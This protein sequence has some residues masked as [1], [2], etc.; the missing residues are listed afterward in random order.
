[1]RTGPSPP[2]AILAYMCPQKRPSGR[3][4][5]LSSALFHRARP[6]AAP[7]RGMARGTSHFSARARRGGHKG[8][9]SLVAYPY[10]YFQPMLSYSYFSYC[11]VVRPLSPKVSCKTQGLCVATTSVR[12]LSSP[13]SDAATAL[14][15]RAPLAAL[16]RRHSPRHARSPRRTLTPPRPSPRAPHSQPSPH[17]LSPCRTSDRG[18]HARHAYS[19]EHATRAEP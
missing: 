16:C 17:A 15:T 8:F 6:P 18:R 2:S 4:F 12:A 19:S 7:H 10:S 11:V 5:N 13:H 1:M 9:A 3:Y 14:G